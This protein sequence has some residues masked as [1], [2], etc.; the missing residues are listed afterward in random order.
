MQSISTGLDQFSAT[1]N[2]LILIG[3]FNIEQEEEN[4]WIKN[5]L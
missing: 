1:Y 5:M 3:D 4:M 2:N